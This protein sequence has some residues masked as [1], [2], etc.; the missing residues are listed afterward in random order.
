MQQSLLC[1]L[2]LTLFA[3]VA[4]GFTLRALWPSEEFPAEGRRNELTA[5]WALTATWLLLSAMAAWTLFLPLGDV[6]KQLVALVLV[7]T[8]LASAVGSG[9]CFK[10]AFAPRASVGV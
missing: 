3:L 8:C 9:A 7:A 2:S 1:G 6:A 4:V 10:A 5:G